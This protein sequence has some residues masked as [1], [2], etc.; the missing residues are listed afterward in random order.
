MQII[1]NDTK[2]KN[3]I[4]K[5]W[6]LGRISEKEMDQM[7]EWLNNKKNNIFMGGLRNE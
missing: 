6:M 3:Q 7:W 5:L 1:L 4:I 2:E